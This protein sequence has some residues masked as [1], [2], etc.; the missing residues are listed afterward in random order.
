[1]F[2]SVYA[3]IRKYLPGM[4]DNLYQSGGAT[5]LLGF[6]SG[7]D[8]KNTI[9]VKVRLSE[10]GIE[11]LV[12]R[13]LG[14]GSNK[15]VK[16][17]VR[18]SG[19]CLA[20]RRHGRIYAY[21]K[22][23]D[24]SGY[25]RDLFAGCEAERLGTATPRDREKVA[26]AQEEIPKIERLLHDEFTMASSVPTAVHTWVVW[27]RHNL[28][29]I[30]G[31]GMEYVD[32]GD[33]FAFLSNIPTPTPCSDD[34]VL[35]AS[36]V[37]F[38]VAQAHEIGILHGD[39]KSPNVLL[40]R[41]PEGSVI[42]LL[43]DFGVARRLPSRNRCVERESTYAAPET[44][45]A[46]AENPVEYSF[47]MD[48]WSLGLTVLDIVYGVRATQKVFDRDSGVSVPGES[49]VKFLRDLPLK[50]PEVDEVILNLMKYNP[51]DRWTAMQASEA[52]LAALR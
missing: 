50:R 19:G 38:A 12:S 17:V 46:S 37:C 14:V 20:E 22:C 23:P 49:V 36:R 35:L 28:T 26:Q 41:T 43:C 32:G 27:R 42:P 24:L 31:I 9:F 2:K 48:S 6:G 21:A 1:M 45:L 18:C 39:V 44:L 25:R 3:T 8:D 7:S 16:G 52:L 13:V 40:K 5:Q 33:L 30:K 29:K 34:L 51:A 4:V 10:T 15:V 11:T 47:S